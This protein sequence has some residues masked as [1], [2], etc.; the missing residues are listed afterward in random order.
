MISTDDDIYRV[1]ERYLGPPG[2]TLAWHARYRAYGVGI[3]VFLGVLILLRGILH[4]PI[5]ARLV[6]VI[7]AATIT[8][9]TIVMKKV[10]PERPFFAVLR[11]GLN[12]LTAPRP[13]TPG[14]VMRPR[15]TAGTRRRTSEAAAPPTRKKATP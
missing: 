2:K 9:T 5:S 4:L 15:F 13:P 7:I 12:D 11:A 1:D 10:T 14:Q 8:I 3:V 6:M